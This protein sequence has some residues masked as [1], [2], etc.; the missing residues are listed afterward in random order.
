MKLEEMRDSL[1]ESIAGQRFKHSVAVY[2]TALKL[3]K[4]HKLDEKL[5]TIE[6]LDNCVKIPAVK[7][8]IV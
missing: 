2:D 5:T 1:E 6:Y 8:Y 4:A 3:A 7:N